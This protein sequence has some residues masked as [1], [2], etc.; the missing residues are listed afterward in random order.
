MK[1]KLLFIAF[2][3]CVFNIHAQLNVWTGTVDDKWS[4]ED[5]W[6]GNVPINS[7]HVLIPSGFAVTVDT[8]VDILSIEVQGNSILNVTSPIIIAQPSEF[9]DNVV[10]NWV[11]G[12]LTGP[13]PLLNSGTIN[14]SFASFDLSGNIVLNNPG[15]INLIGGNIGIS[16]GSFLNNSG[17]GIIDFQVNGGMFPASTGSLNNYGT[18]KTSFP[19]PTD[20]GFIGSDLIN[21]SGTFQIDSGI[22]SINNTAVNLMGGYYN[23]AANAELNLNS[24]MIVSGILAGNVFGNLNW[25]NDMDVS[26][27]AVFNFMGNSIINNTGGD[28][29]GGG[30]LDNQSIINIDV[31]GFVIQDGSDIE[32]NGEIRLTTSSDIRLTSGTTINNNLNGIIDFQFNGGN[33]ESLGIADD[34]RIL[35]NSGLIKVSLPNIND[36]IFIKIKLNNN[37]GIIQIDNGTLNL[38]YGGITLN[39]G[40]YNIASSAILEWSLPITVTGNLSG[41]LLGEL[42]WNANLLSTSIATFN[43]TGN[44]IIDWNS[45]NLEGGGALTNENIIVKSVG[46]TK[47]I[48]NATT[49]NNNGEIRQIVGGTISITTDSVLNNNASG[50]INLQASTSGF[51]AVGNAPNVLNNFGLINADAPSG[52][53]SIS[54]QINNSGTIN[55]VQNGINFSGIL[56]N[57]TSGII[58]GIGTVFLPNNSTNFTNNGVFAPG[59]SPGTLSIV[60]DYES[61]ASSVFNIEL[62]GL[63]QGVDYDLLSIQGDASFDGDVEITLG[64]DANI[65]DEFIVST[66]S[67]NI[68]NCTLPVNKLI[69]YNGSQYEFSIEC[70]NNDEVVLTVTNETLSIDSA[71]DINNSIVLYPNP[72]IDT[73]SFSDDRIELIQIYDLNGKVLLENIGHSISVN[74]LASGLYFVK[75]ITANNNSVI[76]QMIKK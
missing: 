14:L 36:E 68:T 15:T 55:V 61:N 73:I 64:F 27:I 29:I 2:L 28:L 58:K 19:N 7:E 5:N 46:G 47:R 62:D 60:G 13:G 22:L 63:T 9:E 32:N 57:E 8:P 6:S 4:N 26:T 23:V 35:N 49:L 52:N 31:G 30:V 59:A 1:T 41:N 66:I 38:N 72:A 54:C 71:E 12:D 42:N 70:R 48:N 45:G 75:G 11:S 44:G 24:P 50:V 18:I 40:I 67:G 37:N 3:F 20:Q 33:I 74:S 25:D 10:V 43:F 65:G 21:H 16:T 51:S 53:I 39:D 17:T 76:K 56:N 34:T 69:D